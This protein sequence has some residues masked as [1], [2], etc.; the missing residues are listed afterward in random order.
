LS[1]AVTRNCG[2]TRES[3]AGRTSLGRV[4]NR[5]SQEALTEQEHASI[6]I[7]TMSSHFALQLG[8]LAPGAVT[9]HVASSCLTLN[10]SQSHTA[11]LLKQSL[12][13]VSPLSLFV[14]FSMFFT[15][16]ISL[17]SQMLSDLS[18][19][20]SLIVTV[21]S[22]SLFS[23]RHSCRL[24]LSS[25]IKPAYKPGNISL[26]SINPGPSRLNAIWPS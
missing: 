13:R 20:M 26:S 18:R 21:L 16:N 15:V 23:H 24:R 9:Y 4:L 17:K 12:S 6:V 22:S 3:R 5:A 7:V 11:K 1:L 2:Q 14:M 8:V 10:L 19:S 25:Y